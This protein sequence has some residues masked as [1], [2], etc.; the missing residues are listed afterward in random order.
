MDS[1]KKEEPRVLLV[2]DDK[3]VV[4]ILTLSLRSCDFAVTS[5]ETGAEALKRIKEGGFEAVVL[6]L[7][8][9]DGL[10]GAVLKHLQDGKGSGE[11]PAWV[12]ISAF[13]EDEVIRRYGPVKGPFL[14]K[15]FNP[16]ELADMLCRLIAENDR[17]AG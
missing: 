10:G 12:V 5:V 13:D 7:G 16:M 2:E 11:A 3:A 6:D 17:Q 1:G 4:K 14:P 15:P 8:L 9:P